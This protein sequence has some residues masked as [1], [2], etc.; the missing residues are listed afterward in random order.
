[1]VSCEKT[2]M[3]EK[4][5]IK[6]NVQ[7]AWEATSR[8]LTEKIPYPSDIL[9]RLSKSNVVNPLTLFVPWGVRPEGQFGSSEF[10]AL[11]YIDRYRNLLKTLS[12]PS[13]VLLMLADVYA[14]EINSYPKEPT[15]AY[16]AR[17]RKEASAR[18]FEVIPWSIIRNHNQERYRK[19]LQWEGNPEALWRSIP[20]S[21][22]YDGL[23][24]AAYR[25][26]GQNDDQGIRRAAFDYLKERIAEA[27][28]IESV[29]KPIKLSMVSPKKDTI[30]DCDLPRLYILPPEL[31]FPWLKGAI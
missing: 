22:W 11:S 2:R 4:A 25:R 23:L 10:S 15:L 17:V 1:M 20:R 6:Q 12:I 14:L 28:I 24:S 26:S 13:R 27:R 7:L 18:N 30:V 3:K 31:R 19:I 29:Y 9:T 8:M 21:L 16:F 5:P